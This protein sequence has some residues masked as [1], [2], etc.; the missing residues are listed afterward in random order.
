[1][2]SSNIYGSSEDFSCT[3]RCYEGGCLLS[4][5]TE[6]A[7]SEYLPCLGE[8]NRLTSGDIRVLEMPGLATL[9]TLF[10]REH[11]AIAEVVRRNVPGLSN[12]DVFFET[13]RIVNAI[14]QNIVYGE[15]LPVVLGKRYY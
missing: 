12:N 15:F 14:Y 5:A 1:M 10:L 6:E 8:A 7:G 2:D 4:H 9:H 3:L 11:N 13:R